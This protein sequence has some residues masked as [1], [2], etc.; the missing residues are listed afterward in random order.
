MDDDEFET[1]I[2]RSSI[3]AGGRRGLWCGDASPM[4]STSV[5]RAVVERARA[6]GTTAGAR[7]EEEEDEGEDCLEAPSADPGTGMGELLLPDFCAP[8]PFELPLSAILLSLCLSLGEVERGRER[9]NEKERG[10]EGESKREIESVLSLLLC[11]LF[12]HFL[13]LPSSTSTALLRPLS[14]NGPLRVPLELAQAGNLFFFCRFSCQL[15]ETES[16]P[17]P[18]RRSPLEPRGFATAGRPVA[19]CSRNRIALSFSFPFS[20][21]SP[22]PAA[23]A[24]LNSRRCRRCASERLSE[25]SGKEEA[26][27]G[28]LEQGKRKKERECNW[29]V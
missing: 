28:A 17:A 15:Q 29:S 3:A 18:R 2:P 13:L 26:V 5:S 14:L 19:D 23:E 25:P 24:A 22:R 7:E 20:S 21:C 11:S 8:A 1:S 12:I 16:A 27:H 6:A 10:R 4:P 9:K